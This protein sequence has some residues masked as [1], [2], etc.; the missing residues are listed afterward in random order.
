MLSLTYT[1][2]EF[3]ERDQRLDIRWRI[4][5]KVMNE[6]PVVEIFNPAKAV[7]IV[8]LNQDK[9]TVEEIFPK[10][11]HRGKSHQH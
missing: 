7:V 11:I 2:S 10:L 4:K 1:V 9:V 8:S 6:K 3:H 5:A